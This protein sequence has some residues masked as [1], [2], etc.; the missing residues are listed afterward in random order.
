MVAASKERVVEVERFGGLRLPLRG[1]SGY[2]GVRGKQ[3]PNK[4]KYQGYT[5]DKQHTTKL[6]NE[7]QE[8]AVALAALKQNIALGL[9]DTN[10][11]K[12]RSKRNSMAARG[13]QA[14]PPAVHHL[15]ISFVLTC[16]AC[17]VCRS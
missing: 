1:K 13:E 5:Q 11:K 7:P 9:I 8:A 12:P 10:G 6:F 4:D 17:C 16:A 2:I 3:G 14:C 15:S